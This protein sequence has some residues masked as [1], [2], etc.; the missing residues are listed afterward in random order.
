[1]SWFSQL[2]RSVSKSIFS[3]STE[4]KFLPQAPTIMAAGSQWYNIAEIHRKDVLDR[5][6]KEVKEQTDLYSCIDIRDIADI[7]IGDSHIGSYTI[8]LRELHKD[9][10]EDTKEI[11]QMQHFE[12]HKRNMRI[13]F[14]ITRLKIHLHS[15][16]KH[17]RN[18]KAEMI[19]ATQVALIKTKE[20]LVKEV[21]LEN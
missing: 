6:V 16:L 14:L 1:M 2:A 3:N 9:F 15:K 8:Y 11:A 20:T 4:D 18:K 13:F 12:K 7:V 19:F 10:V 5:I 17:L 21:E